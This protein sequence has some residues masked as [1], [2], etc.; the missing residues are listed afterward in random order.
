MSEKTAST[1]VY[2]NH[3]SR[4]NIKPSANTVRLMW[5][6]KD[7]PAPVENKPDFALLE[8][9]FP[10]TPDE[11]TQS[12]G[13][14]FNS[15][16]DLDSA[17]LN[18]YYWG[19]NLDVLEYLLGSPDTPR[20][21][22][23]YIDPP[24]MSQARY[25][26]VIKGKK[27]GQP[28][29]ERNAFTDQWDIDA[30][31][32]MLY[33]RLKLMQQILH[34][35]GSIFVHVDWHV[36]HYVR[37]LL[38]EIF[39]RGN[40]INEIVWCYSGGSNTKKHL[41]RKH[42]MIFWYAR[43]QE[44]TFQPQ[45]RPYTQGTLA[46]GL[47][48]IKGSNYRLSERGAILQDWWTDIN[49]ILSPTAFENLHYPT[50]KPRQLLRR[51]IDMATSPGDLVADFFGGSGTTAEVCEQSDR[52]WL[53]CDNSQ[54]ALQTSLKRLIKA[55]AGSFL[56]FA[57]PLTNTI[58]NQKQTGVILIKTPVIKDCGSNYYWLSVGID[59]FKPPQLPDN[60]NERNFADCIE[61]WEIDIDYNQPVFNSCYQ[62]VRKKKQAEI[63]LD[64]SFYLPKKN[65][66]TIAIKVYD[67]HADQTIKLLHFLP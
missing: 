16:A 26:S 61:F 17:I 30:Y 49:K 53:I 64:I 27:A 29:F 62:V 58:P 13:V 57:N 40:F 42:D 20:P 34:E 11:P 21:R 50:Q 59:F 4:D 48:A 52:R 10:H 63:E 44:Y 45:Y 7:S 2:F 19:D 5:Q 39:G 6:G 38:D 31:L 12:G 32:S 36:S 24:Y 35:H 3:E 1:S 46:R 56:I 22:M 33:P 65:A 37:V 66:Y 25:R 8:R 14:D 60:W 15:A 23:I 55:Q 41:Q 9:V 43:S 54:L 51:L 18:Q 47:T 67:Y 28:S